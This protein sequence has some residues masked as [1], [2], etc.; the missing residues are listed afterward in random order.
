MLHR[1]STQKAMLVISQVGIELT[2]T[3]NRTKMHTNL[4][5]SNRY[6]CESAV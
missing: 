6:K 1:H 4:Q 3:D 2:F 5:C